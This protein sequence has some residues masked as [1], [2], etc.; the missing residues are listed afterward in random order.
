M[1]PDFPVVE[2]FKYVFSVFF[3]ITGALDIMQCV[4]VFVPSD[5]GVCFIFVF[6]DKDSLYNNLGCPG[7]MT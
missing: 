6:Q 3:F 1:S 5:K 7:R 2:F 4:A